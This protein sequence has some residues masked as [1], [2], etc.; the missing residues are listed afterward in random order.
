M[1]ILGPN[2]GVGT[3][4]AKADKQSHALNNYTVTVNVILTG[5]AGGMDYL[6]V[7]VVADQYW[8]GCTTGLR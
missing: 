3:V 2:F 1:P 8:R 4:G 6:G 7:E 5:G